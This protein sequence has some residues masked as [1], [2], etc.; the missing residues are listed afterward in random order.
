MESEDAKHVQPEENW[1]IDV[2]ESAEELTNGEEAKQ[3]PNEESKEEK[4]HEG[5]DQRNKGRRREKITLET[6]VP[7]MPTKEQLLAPP[8]ETQHNAR[9]MEIENQIAAL[10]NQKS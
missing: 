1:D 3:E 2:P 10:R 7:P 9:L 4:K 8:N 5:Q 6:E